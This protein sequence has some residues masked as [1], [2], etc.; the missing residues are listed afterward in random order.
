MAYFLNIRN[1]FLLLTNLMKEITL[2]AK[3]KITISPPP[4]WWTTTYTYENTWQYR[5]T[6]LLKI[7]NSPVRINGFAHKISS[8]PQKIHYEFSPSILINNLYREYPAVK[9]DLCL[10]HKE[11]SISNHFLYAENRLARSQ[12]NFSWLFPLQMMNRYVQECSFIESDIFLQRKE[13]STSNYCYF[14]QNI[15]ARPKKSIMTPPPSKNEQLNLN[16]KLTSDIEC[17]TLTFASE[18][19]MANGEWQMPG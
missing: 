1:S 3:K 8:P 10:D 16:G 18:W 5:R 6:C 9:G 14:A 2:P 12:K 17:Q 13:H 4:K 19:R 11:Q 15:V 7:S